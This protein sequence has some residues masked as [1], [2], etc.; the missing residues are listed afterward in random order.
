MPDPNNTTLIDFNNW[1]VRIRE[2]SDHASSRLL[3]LVHGLTGDENSMWVFASN[4]PSRYWIIA[5]RAPHPAEPG[6][7]SW[8]EKFD[9]SEFGRPTL[10]QLRAGAE[11]LVRLIDEYSVSAGLD[12]GTFD[13]MGFSQGAALCNVL[14]FLY[15]ERIRKTGILAGF[16]PQGS[17]ALIAGRPLADKSFFVA[18]GSKDETVPIDRARDSI[19]LLEQ[20]GAK[21][22]YCED[23]VGH[24]VSANCLRALKEFFT[25]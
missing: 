5:P 21:V 3:V 20:A 8:R 13:L 18:H 10:E 25:D 17:E 4:L 16:V 19:V 12:A 14:A 11:A 23:D 7:Y 6:G 1:T 9:A 22:T 15:P 2:S 24:K